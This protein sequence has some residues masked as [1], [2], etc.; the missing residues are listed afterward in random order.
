MAGVHAGM[1]KGVKPGEAG[2]PRPHGLG[3][4]RQADFHVHH[5]GSHRASELLA[6]A[7]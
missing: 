7:S 5:E 2:G 6:T 1:E 3:G 4:Q